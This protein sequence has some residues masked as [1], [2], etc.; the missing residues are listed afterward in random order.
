[1]IVT[2]SYAEI[3]IAY[4]VGSQ[5]QVYGMKSG[6]AHRHGAAGLEH[7]IAFDLIGS[8][9]EMAVAKA[10]NLY[11]GI[12]MNNTTIDVGGMVE[13]RTVTRDDKR[14]ILHKDDKADLPY[15]LVCNK[16]KTNEFWL[17]GWIFGKEGMLEEYWA[18]PQKTN[19]HAYF[20]PDSK[21]RPI[22]ELK[23]WVK[24]ER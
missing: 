20:V 19:R 8:S 6:S 3:Q 11:W 2:L 21:L 16:L 5:R 9:G 13:V 22:E 23:A 4:A 24:N 17:K 1:M 15:V 18:D 12:E 7:A 10:L 14:L